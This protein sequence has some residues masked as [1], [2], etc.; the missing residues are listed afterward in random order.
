MKVKTRWGLL[1]DRKIKWP[2]RLS[3]EEILEGLREREQQLK[4]NAPSVPTPFPVDKDEL[5]D[6]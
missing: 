3:K 6:K 5:P 4:D 1:E 2:P